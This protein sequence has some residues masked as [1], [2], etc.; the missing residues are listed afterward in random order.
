MMSEALIRVENFTKRYGKLEAVKDISFEVKKGEIFALLGPNGSGKT[1]TLESLEGLRHPD[2]GRLTVCGL[3]P[4][5]QTRKLRNLIGVQLQTSALPPAMTVNEAMVFFCRYHGHQVRQDLVERL[6]LA[7][8][9]KTQYAGLSTGQQRRL[10]LALAVAHEP[11]LL[12]LD[13]PTAGLDV[14]SR[15]ELHALVAEL[16][17]GGTTVILAT[18]DMAEAEKLADRAAILLSGKIAALDSPRRLTAVGAKQTKISVSTEK[19]SLM[20]E[21]PEIPQARFEAA[22]EEYVVY[23]SE[24][25]GPAVTALLARIQAA[26]DRLVDLRVERPSLEE[27][28]LEIT[29]APHKKGGQS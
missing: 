29:A 1:S 8:K 5:R 26:G 22:S 11:S 10:A 12:F 17:G 16:K 14:Q 3:D 6:G 2:G 27:R 21:R 13:E 7:E 4:T 19:K 18:H 15:V 23:S 28:F 9:R 25:P 24:N 20:T